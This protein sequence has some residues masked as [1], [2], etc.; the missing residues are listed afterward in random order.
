MIMKKK[1]LKF[2]LI[3]NSIIEGVSL[4]K[5]KKIPHPKGDI[6]HCIKKSDIGFN[7]FGEAYFS[8]INKGEI[9]A[10][11]RHFE[12]YL[13]LTVPVG[14]V[15]FVIYDSRKESQSFNKY[16]EINLSLENYLRLSISPNLWF[17]FKG[18]KSENLV[19]NIAN[20]EHNPEEQ[21]NIPYDSSIINYDWK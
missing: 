3:K 17:G 10:W 9:K 19:L 16:F 12:M 4:T 6:L 14:E 18:L 1:D 15:K 13:N 20:I 7:E 8:R 2:D 5:L 21:E 11:K